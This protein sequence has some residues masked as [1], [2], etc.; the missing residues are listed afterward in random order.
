MIRLLQVIGTLLAVV[1]CFSGVVRST[2]EDSVAQW[3]DTYSQVFGSD[4]ELVP[5]DRALATVMSLH[6]TIPQ[7]SSITSEMKD[8]VN[9]W[10]DF[11]SNTD[12][13]STCN[14]A[15]LDKYFA[16]RQKSPANLMLGR[17]FDLGQKNLIDICRQKNAD[18]AS[19]V[20]RNLGAHADELALVED[21]YKQ[22][23]TGKIDK[24]SLATK[25]FRSLDVEESLRKSKMVGAWHS[26]PCSQL[27]DAADSFE[28]ESL[29]ELLAL[30]NYN[31]FLASNPY[32][33]AGAVKWARI[34]DVC[35][36]L[37]RMVP[38]LTKY[39]GLKD[40]LGRELNIFKYTSQYQ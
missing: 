17:L 8:K 33:F 5:A 16:A 7:D 3:R 27:E 25:I 18:I 23:E 20:E 6:E 31:D 36:V 13:I 11:L 28:K 1:L 10:Y 39:N 19:S 21:M 12:E 40:K 35:E 15:Y 24:K 37:D 30:A 22:Y 9:T 32:E 14:T 2:E 29:K 26:G 38:E 4:A 34:L